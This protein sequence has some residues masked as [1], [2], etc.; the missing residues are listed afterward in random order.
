MVYKSKDEEDIVRLNICTDDYEKF[1]DDLTS[2]DTI[3]S[4]SL[5]GIILAEVYGVKAVLLKPQIDIVKYYDYY[6]STGRTEFPI[7]NTVEE[8]K[9]I[10]PVDLPDFTE[11]REKLMDEFP[12]D[13]YVG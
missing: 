11:L 8:A 3:I 12:Y 10:E 2:V 4:S 5:H 7:A 13:L 9:N 1:I 6:Y